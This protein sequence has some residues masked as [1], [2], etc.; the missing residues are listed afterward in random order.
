M[1]AMA[2]AG[3]NEFNLADNLSVSDTDDEPAD[4]H[5]TLGLKVS[6]R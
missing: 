1:V 4:D 2:T 6:S 5:I 3:K